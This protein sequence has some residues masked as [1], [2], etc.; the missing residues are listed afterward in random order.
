MN[1]RPYLI[2]NR[3]ADV[4]AMIQILALYKQVSHNEEGIENAAK[5]KPL[6]A[7]K[8]WQIAKEHPE[9]F[10]FSKGI[11]EE[12]ISLIARHAPTTTDNNYESLD[13]EFIIKL[14]ETAIKL[15]DSQLESSRWWAPLIP[16]LGALVG[17]VGTL[18]VLF[19]TK[20]LLK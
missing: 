3:L 18:V 13:G 11:K 6:S 9:F 16:L 10:R 8:W 2:E 1:K 15:H 19:I 4:L 14:M 12:S 5:R 20:F 7:A 17:V